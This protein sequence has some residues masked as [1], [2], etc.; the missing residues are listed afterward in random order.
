MYDT[1]LFDF[2][3][4]LLCTDEVVVSS[5]YHCLEHYGV[6]DVP[7]SRITSTFGALIYDAVDGFITEYSL[8]CTGEEFLDEYR[9]Y[10]DAVFDKCA[11]VYDGIVDLLKN[12]KEKGLKTAVVTT[13]RKSSTHRALDVC[14]IRQYFDY[15]LTS[16]DTP[17]VKPDPRVID[18]TLEALSS[19]PASA[20]MIGDSHFDIQCGHNASILSVFAGWCRPMSKEEIDAIKADVVAY[21]PSDILKMIEEA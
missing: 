19:S 2:D 5:F 6:H 20:M 16:E 7:R 10:H 4:T 15:V 12:L 17:Y 14:S 1:I 11:Y 13:R 9:R 21:R 3:G 8:D 18:V